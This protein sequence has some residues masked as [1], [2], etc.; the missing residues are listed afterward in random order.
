[1]WKLLHEPQRAEKAA[2]TLQSIAKLCAYFMAISDAPKY[3]VTM[4][5][6]PDVFPSFAKV[7]ECN[8]Y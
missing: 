5:Y 8:S 4:A 7:W 3:R 1:M 6:V 2:T